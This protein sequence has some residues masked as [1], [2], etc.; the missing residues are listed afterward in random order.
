MHYIKSLCAL[1][2][3]CALNTMPVLA[4]DTASINET[5]NTSPGSG[6]GY[7]GIFLGSR[8][9]EADW[10]TTETRDPLGDPFDSDLDLTES[11]TNSDSDLGIFAG[12]NWNLGEAWMVGAEADIQLMENN[13][14]IN[15]IPGLE[16]PDPFFPPHS[17]VEIRAEDGVSLRG[18]GG[19][20]L[21]PGLL[22]YGT[23]GVARI[24]VS[25]TGTCPGDFSTCNPFEGT[26]S[27]TTTKQMQGGTFGVGVEYALGTALLRAEYRES[28][29]G[30]FSFTALQESDSSLGADAILDVKSNI[31]EIGLVSGF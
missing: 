19:Y 7:V 27:L 14:R 9:L 28:D 16:D 18:R 17:F 30:D 26:Q 21:T 15:R 2:V 13:A 25:V 10:T 3:I 22:V 12:Y 1:A 24:N 23:A 8:T 6:N 11:V 31:F 20:R 29:F 4:D 5:D